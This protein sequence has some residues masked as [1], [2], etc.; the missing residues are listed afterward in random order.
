ME[1]AR[2]IAGSIPS[3]AEVVAWIEVYEERG[4]LV[5]WPNGQLRVRH[6]DG[7]WLD[8]DQGEA[9][10]HV[11]QSRR[12]AGSPKTVSEAAKEARRKNLEKG[13]SKRWPGSGGT[14]DPRR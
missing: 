12:A 5:K 8:I 14:N 9:W 6:E 10:M 13:R 2:T 3:G 7:E 1:E 11:E 4:A